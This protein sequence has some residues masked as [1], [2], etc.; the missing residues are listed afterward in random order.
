MRTTQTLDE[1]D[2][3][4]ERAHERLDL[5]IMAIMELNSNLAE[6]HALSA[7]THLAPSIFD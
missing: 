1:L 7:Q 6:C 2:A 3:F 4:E 5:F